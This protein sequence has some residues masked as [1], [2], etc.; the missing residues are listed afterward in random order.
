M[1]FFCQLPLKEPLGTTFDTIDWQRDR[2]KK[3]YRTLKE[4]LGTTKHSSEQSKDFIGYSKRC[5]IICIKKIRRNETPAPFVRRNGIRRNGYKPFQSHQVWETGWGKFSGCNVIDGITSDED[6]SKMFSKVS[7]L[8]NSD[9]YQSATNSLLTSW[10]HFKLWPAIFL[11]FFYCCME[12]TWTT[13]E[14]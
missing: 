13:Q 9:P 2:T 4:P 1:S 6:I 8:L 14:G 7:S 11:Y 10:F 3:L 5:T 12:C